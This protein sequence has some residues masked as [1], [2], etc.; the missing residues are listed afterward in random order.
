MT[1]KFKNLIYKRLQNILENLDVDM[2]IQSIL[3]CECMP[4]K[5]LHDIQ[6]ASSFQQPVQLHYVCFLYP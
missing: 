1:T 3:P 6:G 2:W 5:T 4:L